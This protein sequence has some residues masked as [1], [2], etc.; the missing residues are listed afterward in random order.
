[1]QIFLLG[2]LAGVV[3]TR[4]VWGVRRWWSKRT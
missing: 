4:I 1:M 2:F 3:F